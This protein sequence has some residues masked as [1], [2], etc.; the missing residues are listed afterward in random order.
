VYV[1]YHTWEP[2]FE[3]GFKPYTLT[4]ISLA[5]LSLLCRHVLIQSSLGPW[6][7]RE[8][9]TEVRYRESVLVDIHVSAF[10]LC[11]G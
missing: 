3:T 5:L 4:C 6:R 1:L 7:R 10:F 2:Y 8:P 11:P 9:E